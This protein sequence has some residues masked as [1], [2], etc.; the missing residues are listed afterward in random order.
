MRGA[1][2]LR[3]LK[4]APSEALERH[5]LHQKY[6][7]LAASRAKVQSRKDSSS[8]ASLRPVGKQVGISPADYF[9][10]HRI[11]VTI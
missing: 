11:G 2:L 6:L 8:H 10:L 7:V 1:A 3:D 5:E 4:E 9:Q